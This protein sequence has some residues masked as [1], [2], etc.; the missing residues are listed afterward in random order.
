MC[1]DSTK[2]VSPSSSS[3][4]SIA[5]VRDEGFTKLLFDAKSHRVIG[6]A[7][8]GINA[9]DLISEICL[10]VEMGADAEDVG[11]TIHPHPT[12]GESIG[13]A[14]ELYEGACTDLP[15]PRSR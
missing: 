4:R 6:G 13:L 8:V 14:A 1:A 15:P 7:I 10:A 5:N 2:S 9:G 3:G 11:R 12:L